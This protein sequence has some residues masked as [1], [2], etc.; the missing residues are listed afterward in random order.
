MS[1]LGFRMLAALLTGFNQSLDNS[2]LHHFFH[3]FFHLVLRIYVAYE[4]IIFLEY[5]LKF[6]VEMCAQN[7]LNLLKPVKTC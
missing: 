5:F 4:K 2:K 1:Q 3:F 7:C 6:A